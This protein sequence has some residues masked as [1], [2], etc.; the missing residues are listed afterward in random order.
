MPDDSS[1]RLLSSFAVCNNGSYLH[2]EFY[3][4]SIFAYPT[5]LGTPGEQNLNVEFCFIEESALHSSHV[6]LLLT[7]V[8]LQL[9]FRSPNFGENVILYSC[10][11]V[12]K[13]LTLLF[14]YRDLTNLD[15]R[16]N[17]SLLE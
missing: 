12:P 13:I 16:V 9:F 10:L 17:Q 6:I 15:R 14:C 3:L 5:S 4:Y 7:D 1:V 2:T 11:N 8:S